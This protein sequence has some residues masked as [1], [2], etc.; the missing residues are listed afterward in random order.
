M[1]GRELLA[2]MEAA[3]S[4]VRLPHLERLRSL[5]VS[6]AALAALGMDEHT[7]GVARAELR[8]DGL[9]EPSD[10][11]E[12][13]VVEAV[14]DDLNRQL[15]EAGIIDLI[16]W[17]THEPQRWWWRCG[18]AWALGHELL[19]E[20]GGDPVPVVATP[21][22]WLAA[23]GRAICLLDWSDASQ[24]WPALRHGP[25]L[26]F[27]DDALRQRVRNGLVRSAPM[28]TMEINNHAA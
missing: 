10:Q 6:Y 11:G 8:D 15:G 7:F 26:T 21:A 3:A 1:N 19:V 28:P 12:P 22:Y 24:A 2:E 17:R 14:Y 18:T 4:R 16:A 5:G 20:H 27:N 25:P 23:S 13:V 9:F